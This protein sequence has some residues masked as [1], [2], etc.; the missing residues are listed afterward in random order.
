MAHRLAAVV[1]SSL[2]AAALVGLAV[3]PLAGPAGGAPPGAAAAASP[4]VVRVGQVAEQ[5]VPALPGSEPDTL[6]EP[7]VAVSP[8]NSQL[9]VAVAHDGR[10]PDGGAVGISHAWTDDGGRHWHHRPLPG[11]TSATGGDATWTRASDPVAAYDAQGRAYVS[12]LLFNSGCDSAVAV[13]RSTDGGRTFGKPVIVHR[14]ATCAVS[15]DKNWLVVDTSP[16]SPHR[17][18]LYQFWTPF[19]FDIFG[20]F[21]GAPQ[22]VVWSDDRGAT[23]SSP[24]AVSAPHANT[25]NS[26]PM[27]MRDGTIVDSYLDFGPNVA[28]E[29]AGEGLAQ[30]L[31]AAQARPEA[32]Q[33]RRHRQRMQPRAGAAEAEPPLPRLVTRISRDGGR[34]WTD[35]GVISREVG[36][37]PVGIRCCLPSATIDPVT[38]R[39]YAAWS[40]I[41]PREL[42]LATSTDGRS[43]S[44]PRRI[45]RGSGD[46][47][48]VNVD[49]SA[50]GG[51]L[52]VSYGLTNADINFGRFARQYVT[53]SRDAG[54]TFAPAVMVGPRSDYRF[55]AQ[56]GGIFPGDYIGSAMHGDVLYAVWCVSGRP[57]RAGALFHQVEYG[58]TFDTREGLRRRS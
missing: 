19:F 27:L 36:G 43:W 28:E 14:S 56:A 12:T 17:G 53:T 47:Q 42:L 49:V 55:A 15:D 25:Q 48:G 7:D 1:R 11:I 51:T 34:T 46:A 9:A 50:Y 38:D 40:G 45:N 21:D 22:A 3:G 29:G 6:V 39:M 24:V 58:A 54:A 37:G 8:V 10:Y 41:D 31:A 44:S 26:Q 13:S 30:R 5:D 52:G 35:G 2:G 32:L 33:G 16:G 23:W 4:S 18:R 20:N 57:P